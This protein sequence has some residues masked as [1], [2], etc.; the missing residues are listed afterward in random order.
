MKR[1]LFVLV[2]LIT[3]SWEATAFAAKSPDELRQERLVL[4]ERLD[5][6]AQSLPQTLT[7]TRGRKLGSGTYGAV[8]CVSHVVLTPPR[9]MSGEDMGASAEIESEAGAAAGTAVGA[10][11]GTFF[12]LK[13]FYLYYAGEKNIDR[14]PCGMPWC[15]EY[16]IA[17]KS[18]LNEAETL[19]RVRGARF[20]M[21]ILAYD[22][23]DGTKPPAILM[24]LMSINL[25]QLMK[26]PYPVEFRIRVLEKIALG[27]Q[28]LHDKE[29]VHCDLKSSNILVRFSLDL[30][31]IEVV[32]VSD[33]DSA[34]AISEVEPA[35]CTLWFRAPEWILKGEYNSAAD[36]FSF[37]CVM[38]ELLAG[39]NLLMGNAE[40]S[41]LFLIF[42]LAGTPSPG[43]WPGIEKRPHYSPEFPKWRDRRKERLERA[44]PRAAHPYIHLL[45][46]MFSVNP[47]ERPSAADV[48]RELQEIRL[49]IEEGE[50]V[51]RSPSLL[52]SEAKRRRVDTS[53]DSADVVPPEAVRALEA[54]ASI[55]AAH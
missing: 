8:E 20:V 45:E 29:I 34:N 47:A 13:K 35:I 11:V 41:Q 12:A 55:D 49:S 25:E 52:E 37:G 42:Q 23:P 30:K 26:R 40:I 44:L 19:L 10:A 48:A 5:K 21:P 3:N 32:Y 38:A 4:Q 2:I 33:L 24:P 31:E 39:R 15:E 16:Q 50:R 54:G 27:L 9:R 22:P 46:Q 7:W 51:L 43:T 36:I 1:W 28:E 14:C 53:A 18:F 6:L 17:V